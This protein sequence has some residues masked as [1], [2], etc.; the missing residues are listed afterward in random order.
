[1]PSSRE[2][3]ELAKLVQEPVLQLIKRNQNFGP[4]C[5]SD[6]MMS[7]SRSRYKSEDIEQAA[8]LIE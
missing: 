8:D 3:E 1:M 7:N 5:L 2:M 4:T 6:I